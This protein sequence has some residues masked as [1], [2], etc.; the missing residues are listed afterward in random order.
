[1]TPY[2]TDPTPIDLGDGQERFLRVTMT[3]L[4]ALK[5]HAGV[6]I[7]DGKALTLDPDVL[8]ILIAESLTEKN[9]TI[10]Q[11]SDMIDVRALPYIAR[12]VAAALSDGSPEGQS[13]R[14]TQAP[15][16]APVQ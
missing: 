3:T 6:S 12:Q 9:L 11:V 8:P 1:M 15:E 13:D 16:A 14:P 7:L 4:R 2:P 5:K 10:D